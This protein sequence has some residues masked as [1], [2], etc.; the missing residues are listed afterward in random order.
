MKTLL[1]TI[2]FTFSLFAST[3]SV[4]NN[5]ELLNQEIDAISADLTTEEKVTLYYLVLS[6]H[7]KI[8]TSLS[9][10]DD[11][12][13]NLRDIEQKTLSVLS[14]LHENNDK[15]NPEQIERLRLLYIQMNNDAKVLIKAKNSTTNS[16][17]YLAIGL[18]LIM[19]VI[20][21]LIGYFL[22]I[23][24]HI[25]SVD[26]ID[27]SLITN[28]TNE[29]RFFKEEIETLKNEKKQADN[30]NAV[31]AKVTQKMQRD[32]DALAQEN[33]SLK[34]ESINLQNSHINETDKLN[35]KITLLNKNIK[36]FEEQLEYQTNN[37]EE[38][39]ELD[40]KLTSL[41]EQSQ[42]IFKVIDTIS[43][44]ADQTNLLAL[45]AAI[46][47][48][49]AG[50]HGRGFAVVADEVRKLAE[51]TQKTLNE[52]KVNISGLVDTVS[53]LKG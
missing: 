44:I 5:Y 24:K 41:Q 16:S 35:K 11:T 14:N 37:Q 4:Q 2:L 52:A 31:N 7:E 34:S 8:S 21:A 23:S 25:K 28:L 36:E 49:R 22:N 47:A 51:S 10:K 46:E 48:A 17:I 20:G 50:E 13:V 12:L 27:D 29:N 43:D 45:N 38:S 3:A 53:G 26:V 6:T 18:S 32:A 9:L 19:L 39:F 42:D 33:D 40:E 15:L 1:L 30:A